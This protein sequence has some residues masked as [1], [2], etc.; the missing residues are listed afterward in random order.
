MTLVGPALA[1][2]TRTMGAAR[3]RRRCPREITREGPLCPGS[4]PRVARRYRPVTSWSITAA[5]GLPAATRLRSPPGVPVLREQ[6]DQTGLEPRRP[7]L[8]GGS[9]ASFSLGAKQ[10]QTRL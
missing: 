5:R 9:I 6:E 8:V 2:T 3:Q 7:G 10:P 4:S 1:S